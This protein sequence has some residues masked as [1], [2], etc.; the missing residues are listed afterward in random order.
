MTQNLRVM[1]AYQLNM[2][3]GKQSAS[4]LESIITIYLGGSNCGKIYVGYD[5]EKTCSDIYIYRPKYYRTNVKNSYLSKCGFE[6][7]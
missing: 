7:P 4:E 3:C 2:M 1:H 6:R 5:V